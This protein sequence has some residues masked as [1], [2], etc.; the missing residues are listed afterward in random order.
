MPSRFCRP[1][2]GLILLL[3]LSPALFGQKPEPISTNPET[4]NSDGVNNV[5]Q[6]Q[7][8]FLVRAEVDRESKE[9]RD[10]D[11]LSVK[12]ISEVDAHIYVLYQQADGRAF[13]IFPNSAQKDNRVKAKQP[14]EIAAGDD[15]F[16]WKIGAPYGKEF[17]K[18]IA[19]EKPIASLADPKMA[20]RR[21]NP[22]PKGLIRGIT[23]E[24]GPEEGPKKPDDKKKPDDPP[25]KPDNTSP[26]TTKVKLEKDKQRWAEC[27]LEFTTYPPTHIF[28]HEKN[29]RFGVFFGTSKYKFSKYEEEVTGHDSDLA[30]AHRDAIDL[31][32]RMTQEG[33]LTDVQ[34]FTDE[35]A[36]RANMENAVTKWLPSVS[37]PG[38]TVFIYVAG[39]GAQIPDDDGDEADGLDEFLIP[40]DMFSVAAWV[41]MEKHRQEGRLDPKMAEYHR[42]GTA[43]LTECLKK[44]NG[45]VER[46]E[47]LMKQVLCRNTAVTDDL[48]GHWLQML[49]GRQ[50]IV[51]LD[52]C[53]SGG[54]ATN[55][56]NLKSGPIRDVSLPYKDKFDFLDGET[57]RLKDIGQTNT[58]L[59]SACGA[60]ETTIERSDNGL[61][62]ACLME[63]LQKATGK[64]TLPDAHRQVSTSMTT[65]L[66]EINEKRKQVGKPALKMYEPVLYPP[67]NNSFLLKP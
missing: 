11:N 34:L 26:T 9:Y 14:V 1:V 45:N 61:M 31:S 43:V 18:V 37:K 65:Y 59:F 64:L 38:D 42:Y 55:E 3:L 16:R 7:P 46:A 22:I 48:F 51:I 23:L 53:H 29:R 50:V 44:T 36:T 6:E 35:K 5:V 27:L 66:R 15:L 30:V 41:A 62:T 54:F 56:R 10:G 40:H 25:N 63:S 60:Q 47:A 2:F 24:L 39:H 57:I 4:T 17:I 13:L 12:V 20:Q 21:F 28:E 8:T 52:I 49:D 33:R 58:A 19:T 32:K 67:A